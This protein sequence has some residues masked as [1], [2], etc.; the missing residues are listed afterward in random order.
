VR[1]TKVNAAIPNTFLIDFKIA[2]YLF[3]ILVASAKCEPLHDLNR[4]HFSKRETQP[5]PYEDFLWLHFIAR[6]I[7]T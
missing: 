6:K 1:K 7:F 5:V 3:K 4:S 2:A